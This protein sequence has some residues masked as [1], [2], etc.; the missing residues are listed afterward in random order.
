MTTTEKNKTIVTD[1]IGALFTKGDLDAVDQYLAADGVNTARPL[2]PPL[3]GAAWAPRGVVSARSCGLAQRPVV[4][5]GRGDIVVE[6]FTASG[7]HIGADLM[8]V[9]A[10]GETI[11]LQGINVFRL[12]DG[13]IVE[14]WG[15][16]DDLGLLRQLG[17]VD[18]P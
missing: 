7:T 13:R 12:L 1:F 14:R 18:H 5:R 10:A 4:P 2:V 17:L 11:S 15:R 6:V 16:L 9:A 3:T 8:G